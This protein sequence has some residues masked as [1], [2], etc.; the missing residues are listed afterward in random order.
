MLYNSMVTEFNLGDIVNNADFED[1]TSLIPKDIINLIYAPVKIFSNDFIYVFVG[2]E[3]DI[4]YYGV[5]DNIEK[6]TLD[7]IVYDIKKN[8][9]WYNIVIAITKRDKKQLKELSE[10]VNFKELKEAVNEICSV[11]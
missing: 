10:I 1:I 3:G 4:L 6:G 11:V 8:T 2:E 5:L 7:T 9:D